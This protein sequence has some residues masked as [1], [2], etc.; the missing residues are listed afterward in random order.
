MT[1]WTPYRIREL[2]AQLTDRDL[3][4]LEDLERFRLLSTRHIQRLHFGVGHA[5]ESAAT[6]GAV[7][8]LGRLEQHGYL[9]RLVRRIGGARQGSTATIWQLSATGERLLRARR[10]DPLRRR[11]LEPTQGFMAHTLAIAELGVRLR[12]AARRPDLD[13]I[14]LQTEPDCWRSYTDGHGTVQW[15]KPDLYVATADAAFENHAYVEVDL[16]TEHLPTIRRKCQAYQRYFYT[17]TDQAKLGLFP[18][19]VWV[20][21]TRERAERISSVIAEDGSLR[22]AMFVVTTNALAL[23]VLA[24]PG[25]PPEAISTP[26]TERRN[27]L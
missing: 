20:T 12:E 23:A 16:A 6:R 10:G 15:L 27:Q 14:A 17:G 7:R 11:Y 26:G 9:T 8:V 25:E 21:S 5:T 22:D 18:S 4:I 24:P 1:T 3:A 2:L 19:V 13:L